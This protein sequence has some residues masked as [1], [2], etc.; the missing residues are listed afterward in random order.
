M[1][2]M[3]KSR[4][5]CRDLLCGRMGDDEARELLSTAGFADWRAAHRCLLRLAGQ[6][7]ARDPLA[8]LLPH[9]LATLASA[10]EPDRVLVGLERFA[11]TE[12]ATFGRLAAD[13]RAAEILVTLFAGSQFLTEILLRNPAY[14]E[15]LLDRRRLA[16]P[17]GVEELRAEA[18]AAI[19]S[20]DA[21]HQFITRLD[22]L[23][24]FQRGE[25]LRIG[26]S[27]LLG[28][29]GLQAV[30]QQL[31]DLAD[32]LMRVC[33]EVAAA[34][35]ETAADGFC[36]VALGKLG[37]RELNYSSDVDLLFVARE[38]GHAYRRLGEG[39]IEALARVTAEGFLYR[40]DVR[41]RP[42][43]SVGALVSS[44]DAYAAYLAEHARLW[45]KQALLKARPVAGDEQLGSE[46]LRRAER[47][48]YSS[49]I[50]AVRAGA[51]EMKERTEAALRRQGRDWGEV[52]LGEGSIRDVE[53]VVQVLQLAHGAERPGIRSPNTLDALE[54]LAAHGLL[55]ADQHR[56]LADGYVFLR[57]VEHHLQ[58]M[59][60]R[61]THTLPA[62]REPLAHLARRLGFQGE[63]AGDAFVAHYE[64][65]RAAIR[66]VH[67]RHLGSREMK[68]TTESRSEPVPDVRRHLARMDPSY[69]DVF[70]EDD[71]RRHAVL[72]ARVAGDNLVEVE[73]VPLDDAEGCWRVT[74]VG[75]DYPG[76]LSLICGL[77]LA[78]GLN[79][80]SGSVFTY[81][82]KPGAEEEQDPARKIVDEFVVRPV[83]GEVTAGTWA[84]YRDDLAGLLQMMQAG[85]RREARG[86]L[87][88][89]VA[90]ALQDVSGAET[91][92]Y[93][94][95]IEIDNRTSDRYT[96]LHIDA[97]DTLGFLYEF[98]NALAYNR[99]YIARVMVDSAGDRARDT[100]YV[101]DAEE[102][103][104]TAPDRQRE[105]RAATV[106]IKH[107]THVLPRS[108]DPESALLRFRA[109]VGQ[110]FGRPNWPDELASLERSEV[111]DA[112]AQLLGVSDFLWDDF[113]RMQHANLFPVVRDVDAL[114]SA[115]S[116]E[117]LQAE[118]EEAL[119]PVHDGPQPPFD[120]DAPWRETI[121]AFKDREMFRIDM[122]HILGHTAEFGDFSRELTDL[123]EV[124][125]NAV[126]HLCHEDLR[127]VYGTPL[128]EGGELSDVA[129]LALGKC[130]GREMGFASDV[131]LLF[132][133]AGNGKT[134][135]PANVIATSEFYEKM[136]QAF[137]GAIRVR[138]EGVFEIDL[139]L[140]PYGKAGS[141]AVSL[142]AFRRYF[143][144]GGPAWAYERQ[145]LV[146][147][148]PVAGN[149]GLGRRVAELRDEFVYTGE[150][151]DAGA[152]RAMRERQVRHLVAGGTFN[153][154]FSPGGL[155]DLEYLVQGLQIAHG[156]GDASLRRANT[157]EALAALAAA[158]I[159][160]EEEHTRLRKAHT[161]LRWLIDG[162]RMVRG[163]AKDLTVPPAGSEPFAFLARRLRYGSDVERLSDD[164]QQ[165][166]GAVRELVGKLLG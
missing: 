23:R 125:V 65:H 100:L 74:V 159:L 105:L 131:E 147:L 140:R 143:I 43:G 22:A 60:Y 72:A 95:D 117:Q 126:T 26:A 71:V 25:L 29:A 37:G 138:R 134:A 109:F 97:P 39:L 56:V 112:L 116:R 155:V 107:F 7:Q 88:R 57:T 8:D 52:K 123:A 21:A 70:G 103:K 113:L 106:L 115:R 1:P 136:V 92:L 156:H 151:F 54:R 45:E 122:R 44:L 79:I 47:P 18:R 55:V 78:Y 146:R 6:L 62:E 150:P 121:N 38:N 50:E 77:L 101:T 161:F 152:M 20:G 73:G 51:S 164:L 13:P 9:L 3:L 96:V 17:R 30:T 160:A 59:H 102:R 67:L 41:L 68:A 137:L 11:A 63:E 10:A 90:T 111:L 14:F 132:V 135:G 108:P 120:D 2:V 98:T 66:A 49:P 76:E 64:Q 31:S 61:Q 81:E 12:P 133:Y 42:W 89:R 48:V 40:V 83:R 119:R 35:C 148:R 141:L 149:E 36:V 118:L 4:D 91:P 144:P 75:Y 165:H 85:E 15:Q 93:P 82:P 128:L 163:N 162:L 69:T 87:A 104:I 27:D 154:K 129:V 166:T 86:E 158:G 139:Q 114:E 16:A 99:I 19:A 80:E 124:V 34:R 153:A 157:R 5:L 32:C 33:L 24:R 53:F 28:L 58:L 110:L 130:G 142:E 46:F 145:A 94:V 84:R 127:S